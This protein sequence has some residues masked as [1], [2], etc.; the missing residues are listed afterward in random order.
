MDREE[1]V[2]KIIEICRHFSDLH[3]KWLPGDKYDL[4]QTILEKDERRQ[5]LKRKQSSDK[6]EEEEEEEEEEKKGGGGEECE[7][8]K[9]MTEKEDRTVSGLAQSRDL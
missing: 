9:I 6:K 4:T 5:Q 2:V 1:F 3:R 8:D 7:K